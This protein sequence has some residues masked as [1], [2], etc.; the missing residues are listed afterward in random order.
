[1]G[2]FSKLKAM[3]NVVTGG[4]AKVYIDSDP[5]QYD[6]PFNVTVR[7]ET[8]DATVDVSR[9]YLKI[10]G[11]EEVEV[12]DVDVIYDSEGDADRRV[13]NVGARHKT[14][15][16]ELTVA[17]GQELAANQSYEWQIQVELPS[18]APNIYRGR[19]CQHIYSAYA[20][21]GCFGN[22][23]DSGWVELYD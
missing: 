9:V 1:M 3:K 23:P 14:V 6:Q 4:A 19:Y 12:P 11:E 22:D 10:Q 18:N 5:I 16:L 21:L 13:E 8:G 20:G 2:L 17:C 7:A 15:Q